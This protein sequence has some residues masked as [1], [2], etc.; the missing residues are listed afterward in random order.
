MNIHKYKIK[1]GGDLDMSYPKMGWSESISLAVILSGLLLLIHSILSGILF[2]Y[3]G[4]CLLTIGIGVLF[5]VLGQVFWL[6]VI[7]HSDKKTDM[8]SVGK[9]GLYMFY[10]LTGISMIAILLL[11]GSVEIGL[12]IVEGLVGLIFILII[13]L[14]YGLMALFYA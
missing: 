9:I 13:I 11:L 7:F 3:T 6:Y 12:F 10:S 1:L 4:K 14:L 5:I 8:I 2:Y